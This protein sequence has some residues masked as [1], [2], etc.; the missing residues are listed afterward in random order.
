[1]DTALAFDVQRLKDLRR[2]EQW[3]KIAST[4]Q[5]SMQNS[6]LPIRAA[7][8]WSFALA[9]LGKAEE[10]ETIATQVLQAAPSC[11]LAVRTKV[12]LRIQSKQILD[13]LLLSQSMFRPPF[14]MRDPEETAQCVLMLAAI[15]KELGEMDKA[16]K[17]AAESLRLHPTAKGYTFFGIIVFQQGELEQAVNLLTESLKLKSDPEIWNLMADMYRQRNHINDMLRTYE[18]ALKHHPDNE[19]FLVNLGERYSQIHRHEEAERLLLRAIEVNP[20]SATGWV[21][22]AKLYYALQRFD[23][24]GSTFRSALKYSPNNAELLYNLSSIYAKQ[25]EDEKSRSL[26]ADAYKIAPEKDQIALSFALRCEYEGEH[27]VAEQVLAR[28][29]ARNPY[30][31]SVLHTRAKFAHMR[32]KYDEEIDLI[33]Q[34]ITSELWFLKQQPSLEL[35]GSGAAKPMDV[36]DA[37]SVLLEACEFL[38]EIGVTYFLIAG[39]LLG[40]VRDGELLPHD[41]DIDLGIPWDVDREWLMDQIEAS[42]KFTINGGKRPSPEVSEWNFSFVR[43]GTPIALDLFFFKPE[44]DYWLAGFHCKPYPWLHQLKQRMLTTI[45]YKGR[46]IPAPEHPEEMMEET[47]GKNWKIPDPYYDTIIAADNIYSESKCSAKIIGYNR[48]LEKLKERSWKKVVGYCDALKRF[49]KAPILDELAGWLNA[50][51]PKNVNNK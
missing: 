39:T 43:K 9:K 22:L 6:T 21:N 51:M 42:E 36:Y 34:A 10:A 27:E 31:P 40:I 38:E 20:E 19:Q 32:E 15:H 24:C 3:A 47:Y 18:E 7:A 35:F 16:R 46:N 25:D 33:K 12:L 13:A 23:K 41:K 49:E 11:L 26:L 2:D 30:A 45:P 29:V 17:L 5:E 4:V 48:L 28:V 50:A 8:E 14:V 1:M 44:G 37:S